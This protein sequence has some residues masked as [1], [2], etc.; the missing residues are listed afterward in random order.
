[1]QAQVAAFRRKLRADVQEA[2]FHHNQTVSAIHAYESALALTQE[3]LRVQE[4][5]LRNG[6]ATEDAVLRAR[7]EVAGV[8]QQLEEARRDEDAAL[9]YV[10]FL[11]NRPLSTPVDTLS[12]P[13]AEAYA[14]VLADADPSG[15]DS[16]G[17]EELA[18]L[19]KSR[20]AAGQA[21]DAVRA[22]EYPTLG[23]A[24]EGGIQGDGYQAA[25]G[26]NY[27]IGSLVLDWNL[28][29]GMRTRSEAAQARLTERQAARQVDEA[30]LQLDLALRQA[31]R[32]FVSARAALEAAA[33]RRD[34][35]RSAYRLMEVRER[36]GAAAQVAVLDARN[37]LTDSELNFAATRARLFSAA[38]R[39][40]QAATLSPCP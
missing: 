27:A 21:A 1:M 33:A 9:G 23:L 2:Y 6:K 24:V 37:T 39:L 13:D 4:S 19:E 30:H 36:E 20:G 26:R 12:E 15:G 40:D 7:A 3:S 34:A 10:N 22:R 16:A 5:L 28:F 29:D 35:A 8:Q 17:R 14:R 31:R 25:P 11:A 38:A 32:E 18:A